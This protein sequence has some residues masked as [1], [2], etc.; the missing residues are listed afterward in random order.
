MTGSFDFL[1]FNP[2]DVKVLRAIES[3]RTGEAVVN[4]LRA[5]DNAGS[6]VLKAFPLII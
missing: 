6:G 4:L 3:R 5:L 2:I 1:R